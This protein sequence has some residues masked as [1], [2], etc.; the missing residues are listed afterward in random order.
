MLENY[1][2]PELSISMRTTLLR[3]CYF[4]GEKKKTFQRASEKYLNR[5]L[6]ARTEME[7]RGSITH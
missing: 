3:H 6:K 7:V 5:Y 1:S 4:P 2:D